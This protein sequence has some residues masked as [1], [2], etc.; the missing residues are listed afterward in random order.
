MVDCEGVVNGPAL[1]GSPCDD[2]NPSTGNDVYLA[3]CSCLGLLIDCEGV[4]GGGALPGATCDD[5]DS[6]TVNDAYDSSCSCVGIPVV[7]D[8]EGVPNG[9]ALPGTPCSDGDATTGNDVFLADCSCLGQ[10]IDCAGVPGGNAIPGAPCD[11]GDPVTINDQYDGACNCTG[12]PTLIDCEGIAGGTA[13]PG[14]P[15]D[16]T[17]PATGNDVYLADCS[18]QGEL[19]DCNGVPGGSDLPGTACDDGLATTSNDTWDASCNC[20][21]TTIPSNS[22]CVSVSTSSDGD[23][24][25]AQ[26]GDVYANA[27]ALDL[28]YDSELPWNFRGDQHIGLRFENILVPQGASITSAYIQFTAADTVNYDPIDLRIHAEDV[29]N[30]GILNALSGDVSNRTKTGAS[31]NWSPP[32]WTVLNVAGIDQQTPNIA[33]A[34]QEVINRAGWQSGNALTLLIEGFGGRQAYSQNMDPS[35]APQLCIEYV[36]TV[37]PVD[38]EGVQGG[39]AWPGAPCD[40]ND[41]NTVQD[42]WGPNCNCLGLPLDCAGVINGSSLPGTPCDDGD[43]ATGD[44]RYNADCNCLGLLID[45]AGVPGGNAV[46]DLCGVCDGNNACLGTPSCYDVDLQFGDAEEASNGNLY[47]DAGSLDLVFDS[48]LPWNWRGDQLVGLRFSNIDVPQGAFI[49]SA[50]IQFTAFDTVAYQPCMLTIRAEDSPNAPWIGWSV[51]ELSGRSTTNSSVSWSPEPWNTIDESGFDQRTP[52]LSALVQEIVDKQAWNP[53]NAMLFLVSGIGGRQAYSSELDMTRSP[54]LCITYSTP[55]QAELRSAKDFVR[56]MIYPNPN[57]GD[58]L[59]VRVARSS[60]LAT[61]AT[62]TIVDMYGKEL[63][64]EQATVASTAFEKEIYLNE[65]LSQ[66]IY[67]VN[68]R[69]DGKQITKRLV[70]H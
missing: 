19:I 4:A 23:M 67:Y 7:V 55:A 64:F 13:L 8:C 1:P 45:C 49:T 18:C 59:Y 70:V 37:L 44:D 40:D 58:H 32:Q 26:N 11:D 66:G 20:T 69:V 33:I 15:C 5:G 36:P 31:V 22:V 9:P 43:P 38:C 35:K 3:D 65:A 51:G 21:G 47:Q 6:S 25:E 50:S 29:D 56:S 54:R 48:E 10:L 53:S 12:T 62:I 27:G 14:T 34:V 28:V 42:T 16:D 60:E 2:N 57:R 39:V 63:H 52:D 68:V 46:T 30:A 24:E 61:L 17:D 41:S